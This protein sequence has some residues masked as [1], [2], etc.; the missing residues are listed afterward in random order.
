MNKE[1]EEILG[2]KS[3]IENENFPID[4]EFNKD[5][6]QINPQMLLDENYK[7]F[8]LYSKLYDKNIIL[9]NKLQS[10]VYEKIQLKQYISK[11]EVIY[12]II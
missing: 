10:L 8:L 12:T 7:Y 3:L 6:S 2:I 4:F 5:P 9:K 1:I 11:L